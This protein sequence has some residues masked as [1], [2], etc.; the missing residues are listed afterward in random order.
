MAKSV[1]ALVVATGTGAQLVSERPKPIHVLC[2]RPMLAWVL[3][4]VSDAGV[5]QAVIVTGR[6][7]EW[8]SKRIMDSPPVKL[9]TRFIEQPKP[10]GTAEAALIGMSAFDDFDDEG[11]LLILP[12]DMPLVTGPVLESLLSA[13]RKSGAACTVVTTMR[14]DTAGAPKIVRDRHHRPIG[15]SVSHNDPSADAPEVESPVGV[16]VVRRGLLSPAI[17]RTLPD[18]A[19]GRHLLRDVPGVLADSGH[20]VATLDLATDA[21]AEVDSRLHLAEAEA[22]LRDR[23]NLH[24]MERG[25]TMIDPSRTR[26]DATVILAP[27]VTLFPGVALSGNTNIAE[28]CDIGPDAHL[29]HCTVGARS[30]IRST[31]AQL[32]TIG[33]QCIVGPYAALRPGAELPDRTVTGPFYAAEA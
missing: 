11:D 2:G 22:V 1:S 28:G 24:W 16:Y 25:V 17:R 20:L 13:H 8:I 30:T 10:R 4:A 26:I 5:R 3:Q 7:G 29:D 21:F 23:T 18:P 12:A 27:D 14:S 6:D 33:E 32:A 9:T 15:I 31:T 19:T